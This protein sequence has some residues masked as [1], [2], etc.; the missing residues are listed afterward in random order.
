M[1]QT[2]PQDTPAIPDG[3][4]EVHGK[5]YMGDGKGGLT[6]VENIKAQH[7]LQDELVREIVGDA[8][9]LSDAV[10]G[11]KEATF[12]RI[13][14]FDAMLA[15]EYNASIGGKKGNKTFTSVDGLYQV[16][17]AVSDHLEFGPE[18]QVAKGL[19]DECLREWSAD[20]RPEIRSVI[21]N[22]FNTDKEG[23]INRAEV[24]KLLKLD[25]DD[26]RWNRAM[27]A[28][29]DAIRT[30]G[31]TTYVRCYK[32][33]SHDAKFEPVVIDLARA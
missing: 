22:A 1:T 25:I 3:R 17:V 26:A 21:T 19:T 24:F 15:Q 12:N 27:D 9:T 33:A 11:F 2:I 6:P 29:R 23:Q 14:A 10:S 7:L 13:G 18:L 30:V 4:I 16:K 31:S 28:I 32:R 20:S 8:M 5:V